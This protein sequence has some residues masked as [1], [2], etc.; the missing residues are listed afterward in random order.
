MAVIKKAWSSTYQHDWDDDSWTTDT[1]TT[2]IETLSGTTE[3]YTGKIDLA[4]N[5]YEGCQIT[6]DLNYDATPTD[7]IEISVYASIDGTNWDEVAIYG[8]TGD[9]DVDPQQISII[10]KDVAY[11]RVGFVQSGSTDSHDITTVYY[12]AWRWETA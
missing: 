4:T 12:K 11:L 9:H 8:M 10:I 5:G 2:A 6:F 3:S 1:P 7:E